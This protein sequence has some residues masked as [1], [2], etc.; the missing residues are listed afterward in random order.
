MK[1]DP[2]FVNRQKYDEAKAKASEEFERKKNEVLTQL[3]GFGNALL[4]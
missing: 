3:K 1:I 4:G 2:T